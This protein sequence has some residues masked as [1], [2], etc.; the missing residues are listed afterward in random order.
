MWVDQAL[1]PG[2]DLLTQALVIRARYDASVTLTT[3]EMDEDTTT[4]IVAV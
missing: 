2:D 1:G 4:A 3:F